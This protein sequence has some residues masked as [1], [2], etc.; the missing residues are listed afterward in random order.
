VG[1]QVNQQDTGMARFRL[2]RREAA[3]ILVMAY[4]S[5]STQHRV[6]NQML[7][8]MLSPKTWQEIVSALRPLTK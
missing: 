1:P 7:P 2:S 5:Q 8:L 4:D 6:V 3:R